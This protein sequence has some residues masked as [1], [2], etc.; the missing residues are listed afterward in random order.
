MSAKVIDKLYYFIKGWW[1]RD[2][3]REKQVGECVIEKGGDG[4]EVEERGDLDPCLST[5]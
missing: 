3:W 2:G 4:P 1:L 5:L